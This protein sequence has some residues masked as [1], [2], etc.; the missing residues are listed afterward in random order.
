[1]LDFMSYFIAVIITIP[2]FATLVVHFFAKKVFKTKRRAIFIAI[3]WTNI[4]YIIAV[5]L[6]IKIIFD[7]QIGSITLILILLGLSAVHIFQWNTGREVSFLRAFKVVWRFS[8]LLF[9]V[10]YILLLIIGLIQLLMGV[11]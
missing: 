6:L 9:F 5:H 11:F 1:M 2:I 4:F 3:N 7:I 8:F 10:L